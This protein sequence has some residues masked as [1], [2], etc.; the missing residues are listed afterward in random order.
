[1]KQFNYTK[2]LFDYGT[3]F[4]L[5]LLCA[6]FSYVTI[7]EQSPT[8]PAAAERLA[9]RVGDEL[10]DG[11]S[12][13]VL[14]RQG[15]EGESFANALT[16]QL[17]KAGVT[18]AATTIGQ[19]VDARKALTDFAATGVELTGICGRMT[20]SIAGAHCVVTMLSLWG[21]EQLP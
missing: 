1:M 8:S 11:A 17:A 14:V 4:V 12:V 18:V 21:R 5:A 10:P 9:K 15:G 13:L 2:L 19:P 6:W 3:L 16:E 20:P 7:E